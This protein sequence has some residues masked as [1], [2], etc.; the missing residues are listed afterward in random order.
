MV[1]SVHPTVPFPCFIASLTCFF[2]SLIVVASMGLRYV[3]NDMLNNVVNLIACVSMNY[4]NPHKQIAK[5]V[6]FH[7]KSKNA[8]SPGP[9]HHGAHG[10]D[11]AAGF[12]LYTVLGAAC[13]HASLS[14]PM[15][16]RARVFLQGSTWAALFARR[17]ENS[18]TQRPPRIPWHM[19]GH[20]S[21]PFTKLKNDKLRAPVPPPYMGHMVHAPT[22]TVHAPHASFKNTVHDKKK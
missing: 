2:A 5:G 11:T 16:V 21:R 22:Y 10:P 4:Q 12:Y 18:Q 15:G 6:M 19:L 3:Y 17:R 13:M 14:Y 20:D 7:T 1:P 8:R 9:Q